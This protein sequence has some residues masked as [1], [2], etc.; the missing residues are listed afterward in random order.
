MGAWL[1]RP[2]GVLTEEPSGKL[3]VLYCSGVVLRGVPVGYR[4]QIPPSFT[5]IVP[6]LFSLHTP[7]RVLECTCL[8]FGA[9]FL[10]SFSAL[11]SQMVLTGFTFTWW[12]RVVTTLQLYEG[13]AYCLAGGVHRGRGGGVFQ[14]SPGGCSCC[15]FRFRLLLPPPSILWHCLLLVCGCCGV[16][17]AGVSPRQ[18]CQRGLVSF[19]LC[20][21]SVCVCVCGCVCVCV[22]VSVAV[23]AHTYP[24]DLAVFNGVCG[25]LCVG[26]TTPLLLCRGR[27]YKLCRGGLQSPLGGS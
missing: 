8:A 22:C 14:R 24:L 10:S 1:H 11:D 18:G 17:H 21:V 9:G 25:F 16:I 19:V 6:V 2:Q 23:S 3:P 7:R 4:Q 27:V 26:F 20:S 5:R 12:C 15:V 13:C